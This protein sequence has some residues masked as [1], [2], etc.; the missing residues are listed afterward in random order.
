MDLF[1]TQKAGPKKK[2]QL[3]QPGRLLKTIDFMSFASVGLEDQLLEA[4]REMFGSN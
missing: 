4:K 3:Q 1:P 2:E